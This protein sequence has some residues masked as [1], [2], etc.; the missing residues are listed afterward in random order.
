MSETIYPASVNSSCMYFQVLLYSSISKD[1]PNVPSTSQAR[2]I[3][4]QPNT[5]HTAQGTHTLE[6]GKHLH[7]LRGKKILPHPGLAFVLQLPVIWG[8]ELLSLK[9][10]HL[11]RFV[12]FPASIPQAAKK[13]LCQQK[14]EDGWLE[15][16]QPLLS[17]AVLAALAP[18]VHPTTGSSSDPCYYPK[19]FIRNRAS[20]VSIHIQT[21]L[22][23]HSCLNTLYW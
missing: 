14:G 10:F 15:G 1:V 17:A 16:K 3:A 12:E 23:L 4:L 13:H 11:A 9:T 18:F 21:A 2:L 20:P 5:N 8:G 7:C 22:N 6:A 19:E